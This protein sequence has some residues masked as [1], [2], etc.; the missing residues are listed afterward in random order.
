MNTGAK[1]GK[2][3]KYGFNLDKVLSIHEVV[4]I[5]GV[6]LSLLHMRM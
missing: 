3:S 2:K 6:I 5:F 4:V 1:H